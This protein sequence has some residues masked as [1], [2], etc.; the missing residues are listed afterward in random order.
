[1]GEQ[2]LEFLTW[3]AEQP[4]LAAQWLFG[5]SLNVPFAKGEATKIELLA[6]VACS[7]VMTPR[8][9]SS[10]IQPSSRGG[11]SNEINKSGLETEPDWAAQGGG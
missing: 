6:S 3:V 10:L 11:S 9:Y 1:M 7:K 8:F 4:D 2:F 5:L